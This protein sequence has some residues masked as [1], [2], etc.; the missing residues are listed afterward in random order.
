MSCSR[1]E[2]VAHQYLVVGQVIAQ[3]LHQLGQMGAAVASHS[4]LPLMVAT[5][6]DADGWVCREMGEAWRGLM[7]Q[8]VQIFEGSWEDEEYEAWLN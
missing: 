2:D 7:V 3:G 5:L 8:G 1:N 4:E 6:H